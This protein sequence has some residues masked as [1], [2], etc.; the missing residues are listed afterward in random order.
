MLDHMDLENLES[1]F[2]DLNPAKDFQGEIHQPS[3]RPN[4]FDQVQ[5]LKQE[6]MLLGDCPTGSGGLGKGNFNFKGLYKTSPGK[7]FKQEESTRGFDD[8]HTTKGGEKSKSIVLSK[9]DE[10]KS[11]SK[12]ATPPVPKKVLDSS[13]GEVLISDP[14][15]QG[16]TGSSLLN[17]PVQ[18]EYMNQKF[19]PDEDGLEDPGDFDQEVHSAWR[20]ANNYQQ[21][22][23]IIEMVAGDR[24]VSPSENADQSRVLD[25]I[26]LK[27]IAK[28]SSDG[29]DRKDAGGQDKTDAGNF[30]NISKTDAGNFTNIS[31]TDAGNFTNISKTDAGNFTNVS[32][33]TLEKK[34]II[35]DHEDHWGDS[36]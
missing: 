16:M 27:I 32:V 29:K 1:K 23:S 22:K 10:V 17:G 21:N 8:D 30:T 4:L 11:N 33:K 26:E 19:L 28:E 25:P 20:L 34:D 9:V 14:D 7:E 5:D 2:G 15:T 18:A 12:H 31:K 6:T 36:G 24:P 3:D 35:D 13:E